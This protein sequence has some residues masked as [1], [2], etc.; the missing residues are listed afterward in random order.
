MTKKRNLAALQT[1]ETTSPNVVTKK[2]SQ[3]N[4]LWNWMEYKKPKTKGTPYQY[5]SLAETGISHDGMH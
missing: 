1:Y 4:S 2:R 3:L 5:C